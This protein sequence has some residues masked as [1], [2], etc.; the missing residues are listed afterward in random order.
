MSDTDTP[1]SGQQ[2]AALQKQMAGTIDRILR[3]VELRKYAVEAACKIV[4]A[5]NGARD[6]QVTFHDPI[7]LAKAM[8]DFLTAAVVE[9]MPATPA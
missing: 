9:A 3:D 8:H 7:A 4:T 5:T 1:M 6:G 2:V